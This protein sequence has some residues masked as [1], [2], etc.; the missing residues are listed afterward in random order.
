MQEANCSITV[1]HAA[2]ATPHLNININMG[3][4]MVFIM[5]PKSYIPLNILAVRPCQA[6]HAVYYNQHRHTKCGY[7]RIIQRIRHY[8]FICAE[9]NVSSCGKDSRMKIVYNSPNTSIITNA[10]ATAFFALS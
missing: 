9:Q 8:F 10:D 6:A 3:S 7:S 2:P 4:G 1:A 5:A